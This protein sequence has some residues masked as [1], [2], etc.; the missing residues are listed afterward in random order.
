ML[1]KT[2]HIQNFQSHSHTKIDF[3]KGLNV[4]IGQ[5][6]TGKSSILRALRKLIR[7]DPAGKH[8][9][10][11][12]QSECAITL[13]VSNGIKEYQIIRKITPSKNLYYLD[14]HE[15]GG[16]GR[17]IPAEVQNTLEMYLIVLENGEKIDLHFVDQ[18]DTP[19][20]VSRGA[21]GT[22][23]KI[24][25]HVGGLH[26]LDSA[27]ARVNKDIGINKAA[28]SN[29]EQEKEQ[30][31]A[32][33][34][35]SMDLKNARRTLERLTTDLDECAQQQKLLNFLINA[36]TKFSQ[37]VSQGKDIKQTLE[38]FPEVAENFG[39]LR[40]QIQQLQTLEHL[41]AQ[42][43]TIDRQIDQGVSQAVP[44]IVAD[45]SCINQQQEQLNNLIDIQNALNAIEA[46]KIQLT[47]AVEKSRGQLEKMRQEYRKILR[48]L[49]ICP[50]CNQ[51]TV[52]IE[53]NI[54]V[55]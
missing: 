42:L 4:I 49:K 25:G 51:S 6:N 13:T 43:N 22:R 41:W 12:N 1:F 48:A 24:L 16:F 34:G 33:L 44:E 52:N 30:I 37:I 54:N 31:C 53:G 27:I 47:A 19:F 17:E 29:A 23:S 3:T 18:H 39:A 55:I 21:A 9:I 5:S 36:Q 15:F 35:N 2:L 11:R 10:R 40:N 28:Q 26:I 7:D 8:F 14:G 20:M 38:T 46:E 32:A 50:T 45:F